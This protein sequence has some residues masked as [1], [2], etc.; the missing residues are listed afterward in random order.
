MAAPLG[1]LKT[2]FI[3]VALIYLIS[4]WDIIPDFFGILGRVDDLLLVGFLIWRYY[5]RVKTY[6][7]QGKFYKERLNSS[8][9]NSNAAASAQKVKPD[10]YVVLELNKGATEE[11]LRTAYKRLIA[12]YHPD[13]VNHLGVELKELAHRKTLEIT[14]AYEELLKTLAGA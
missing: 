10:P 2:L 13:K 11:E 6:A 3:I 8:E 14:R 4:P 1:T 7:E 9:R 5:A 12:L